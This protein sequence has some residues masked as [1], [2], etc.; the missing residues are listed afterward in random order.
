MTAEAIPSAIPGV[1]T[2]DEE[3]LKALALS[4]DDLDEVG[5]EGFVERANEWAGTDY[6]RRSKAVALAAVAGGTLAMGT[7]GLRGLQHRGVVGH[8]ARA[9]EGTDSPIIM[10]YVEEMLSPDNAHLFKTELSETAA[11]YL[12][13]RASERLDEDKTIGEG[14][15]VQRLSPNAKVHLKN[16]AQGCVPFGWKKEKSD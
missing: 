4:L 7:K 14:S 9:W 1:G 12:Q 10:R 15:T 13:K 6:D 11:T 3:Q 8:F 16:I 5:F 2:I